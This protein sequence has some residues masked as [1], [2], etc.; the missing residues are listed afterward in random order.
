MD[1]VLIIEPDLVTQAVRTLVLGTL[2]RY[3]NGFAVEWH[4]A[5][6]AVFLVY[7]FGEVSKSMWLKIVIIQART[8]YTFSQVEEKDVQRSAWLPLSQRTRER[9]LIIPSILLLLTGKFFWRSSS[10]VSPA[11]LIVRSSCSSSKLL[12]DMA[13]FSRYVKIASCRL[14]KPWWI[15]GKLSIVRHSLVLICF[16]EDFTV[17]NIPFADER[18]T[19]FIDS[20]GKARMIF[21]RNL[22]LVYSKVS[23]IF[24]S[25]KWIYQS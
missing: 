12:L 24:S 9:R 1:S 6:L 3:R 18:I 5:E 22:R 19:S 2:T 16:L 15:Y 21:R 17:P 7:I 23:E 10:L 25:F 11:I 4:D 14:L 8:E 20:S 13:T